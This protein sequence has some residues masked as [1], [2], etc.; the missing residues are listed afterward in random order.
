[1]VQLSEETTIAQPP[2]EVWR[3]LAN[4]A[5]ISQWAPNVDH[6]CLMAEQGEGIGT[7]RRIQSG[8]ATVLERVVQWEP[9]RCMAYEIEGL[10]PVVRSVTNEWRLSR[11]GD[12][13]RVTLT[14]TIDTGPRPPQQVMAKVVGRVLT[15]AS[16][17]M[18]SGLKHAVE[19]PQATEA[20]LGGGTG[21]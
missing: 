18:L 17:E 8:R 19:S 2:D 6:S 14:S 15:K 12:D 21:P 4:F 5:G 10:P 11:D 9:A 16:R 13:T 3:V 1:M 20:K 7:V